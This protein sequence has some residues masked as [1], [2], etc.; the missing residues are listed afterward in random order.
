[1]M[2]IF[3]THI[4]RL[5]DENQE[6][7]LGKDSGNGLEQLIKNVHYDRDRD[8]LSA[9]KRSYHAME[10]LCGTSAHHFIIQDSRFKVIGKQIWSPSKPVPLTEGFFSAYDGVVTRLFD[11]FLPTSHGNFNHFAK[12]FQHLVRRH[13]VDMLDILFLQN[14]GATLFFDRMLPYIQESAVTDSVLAVVFVRDINAE[15][16]EKREAAHSRLSELGLIQWLTKAIQTKS[17]PSFSE[18]AG[19]LLVRI[20]EEA[21]QVENGHL[22]LETLGNTDSKGKE[23]IDSFVKVKRMDSTI[24]QNIWLIPCLLYSWWWIRALLEAGILLLNY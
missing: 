15:T 19:E 11:V 8:D 4:S 3:M 17:S 1:M 23:Q 16:K 13:P 6:V 18:A 5:S 24:E 22:L 14:D 20:I 10:I 7:T 12:I 21:S 2:D 9:L